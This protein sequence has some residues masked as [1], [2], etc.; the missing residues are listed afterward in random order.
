MQLALRNA[1]YASL[2]ST[3]RIFVTIVNHAHS[4]YALIAHKANGCMRQWSQKNESDQCV[5]ATAVLITLK[6][7]RM[8]LTR[9]YEQWIFTQLIR[10]LTTLSGK[11]LISTLSCCT[12]PM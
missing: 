9:L 4:S 2:S 12:R 6:K 7:V 5:D 3:S 1:S 10:P 8:I 11:R